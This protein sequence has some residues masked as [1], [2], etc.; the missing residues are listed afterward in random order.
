VVYVIGGR[1]GIDN[2]YIILPEN[3]M[4]EQDPGKT[5]YGGCCRKLPENNCFGDGFIG[6]IFPMRF[7]GAETH[8]HARNTGVLFDLVS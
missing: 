1:T 5:H 8:K 2:G 7:L 3:N 6:K 4:Q